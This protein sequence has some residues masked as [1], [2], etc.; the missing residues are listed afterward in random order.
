MKQCDFKGAISYYPMLPLERI[1]REVAENCKGPCTLSE[2]LSR[3]G[4]RLHEWV[5][6]ARN[7]FSRLR[8]MSFFSKQCR[9]E[10][11]E[12]QAD[13]GHPVRRFVL[14]EVCAH[15]AAGRGDIDIED[16]CNAAP[17]LRGILSAGK[18]PSCD[19]LISL[20]GKNDVVDSLVREAVRRAVYSGEGE[21]IA[22]LVTAKL[23]GEGFIHPVLLDIF[24]EHRIDA[25]PAGAAADLLERSENNPEFCLALLRYIGECGFCELV[26]LLLAK[27]AKDTGG[28]P[29]MH[30][31]IVDTLSQ[32]A[33]GDTR[34]R[35]I[36]AF[37]RVRLRELARGDTVLGEYLLAAAG[38]FEN[39]ETDRK[40]I[41]KT[42]RDK[43]EGYTLVQ[44]CFYG[45]IT[46]PGME[47]GGGIATLLSHLGKS[48]AKSDGC[49]G[50]YTIVLLPVP[51]GY[52]SRK[53]CE[54]WGDDRHRILRIPVFFHPRN[55]V[56]QF[57]H[58]EYELMRAVERTLKIYRI[59]PDI[60][61][62][63]YADNAT[64]AVCVLARRLGK[65][66]VYTLTPDPH[67]TFSD[68][69]GKL[70]RISDRNAGERLNRVWV[71]DTVL[72]ES[73]GFL[74][75]GH[76]EKNEE[77]LPYFP[78]L[79]LTDKLR[80]KPVEVL[81]EGVD[82]NVPLESGE[83]YR[84][85]ARRITRGSHR[86]R[87]DETFMKRPIL[88]NVGRLNPVKGQHLLVE[89]WAGSSLSGLYNLVLV[90]G[91]I[92]KPSG[93]EKEI[94]HKIDIVMERHIDCTGKLCMLGALPNREVRILE[95]ALMRM[96]R[97]ATPHV[98]MCSSRKEEFGISIIE[99]MSEGYL[100]IAPLE[101]GVSS[102]VTHG[103]NGYLIRTES[104][105]DIR[106]GMESV[107]DSGCTESELRIVAQHGK[108]YARGAFDVDRIGEVYGN[109]YSSLTG[110]ESDRLIDGIAGEE[111]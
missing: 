59:E 45:D 25:I 80:A 79:W 1:C 57:L 90:G 109:F 35:V 20:V 50:V 44:C 74:L 68:K 40:K 17:L 108:Q 102:Y 8:Y 62:L 54:R 106:E 14:Q 55:H 67:R 19:R 83:S 105:R 72:N 48:I 9:L 104:A 27:L 29:A 7:D 23:A 61:H 16:S 43:G 33:C 41:D 76:G 4:E 52:P 30:F 111:K 15:I 100:V 107:L 12:Y 75:I 82:M 13:D 39:R 49:R 89:A 53:L 21:N 5:P 42:R 47:E 77:I 85:A 81:S 87:I 2:L 91:N 78:G 96:I 86:Y 95:R 64:R 58:R 70:R 66:L 98:Y 93:H 11:G 46:H 51:G 37:E 71:A 24:A 22:R 32:I 6:C 101:G 97:C 3:I 31:A 73:H 56:Q 36:D 26:P 10:K 110:R 69:N 103:R 60:F 38:T 99:A 18:I 65:K 88:L 94:L 63:R 28:K 34:E 84:D 92:E